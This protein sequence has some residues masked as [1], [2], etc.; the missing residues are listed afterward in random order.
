MTIGFDLAGNL[1]GISSYGKLSYGLKE[2]SRVAAF[3]PTFASDVTVSA[4]VVFSGD[5]APAVSFAAD[6]GVVFGVSGD[7]A[8]AISFGADLDVVGFVDFGGDLAPQIALGGSL[9]LD[10]SLTT[11]DGS[12]GFTV[13]YGALEFV[14]G[15]LWAS[16]EPCPSLPWAPSEPC[17]PSMWTPTDPCAPADWEETEL[18]N[19]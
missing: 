19:G 14:S 2:Y 12:F 8:P 5:L 11:L 16:S 10:L 15:P 4:G 13:V 6:L 9:S 3:A 17:P 1:G 7:L 18:C